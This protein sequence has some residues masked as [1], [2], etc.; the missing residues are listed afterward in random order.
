MCRSEMLVGDT[1][2][3]KTDQ[4][5]S[6]QLRLSIGNVRQNWTASEHGA[7][8][9]VPGHTSM[10]TMTACPWESVTDTNPLRI[11]SVIQYATCTQSSSTLSAKGA[12][13]TIYCQEN[14]VTLPY[15]L[16]ER[17]PMGGGDPGPCDLHVTSVPVSCVAAF[18]LQS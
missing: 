13:D 16:C 7:N 3:R 6:Y 15:V 14:H 12:T 8:T 9:F 1:G 4:D 11:P 10:K 18:P 17:E 2:R 5:S